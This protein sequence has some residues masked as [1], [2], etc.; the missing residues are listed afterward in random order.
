MQSPGR[1]H[2]TSNARQ[3]CCTNTQ[4]GQRHTYIDRRSGGGGI[5]VVTGDELHALLEVLSLD[6][7]EG[8]PVVTGDELHALL[9]VLSLDGKE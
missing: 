7:E 9:E 6:G 8:I 5:P 3:S 1:S 4:T 2:T